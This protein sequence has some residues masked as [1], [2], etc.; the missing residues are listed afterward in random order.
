MKSSVYL[1]ARNGISRRGGLKEPAWS[2]ASPSLAHRVL[3][4]VGRADQ[5]SHSNRYTAGLYSE[6]LEALVL[7]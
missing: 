7:F 4:F 5:K 2:L 3:E 6:I 1:G